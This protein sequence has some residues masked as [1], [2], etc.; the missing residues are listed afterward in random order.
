MA[1]ECRLPFETEKEEILHLRRSRKKK[2]ADRKYVKWL[3]VIFD[4]YVG[5]RIGLEGAK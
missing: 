5:S 3:G 4:D 1:E 2:N